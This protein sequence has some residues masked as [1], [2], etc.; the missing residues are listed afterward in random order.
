MPDP[1]H[2]SSVGWII[3]SLAALAMAFNQIDDFVKRRQGKDGDRMV[4]P[5][6]FEIKAATEY[7]HKH[8][9]VE[10]AKHNTNT[11]NAM[12]SALRASEEKQAVNLKN[13]LAAIR[14]EVT[15]MGKQV[16]AIDS[17]ME[18]QNQQ[19]ARIETNVFNALRKA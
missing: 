3:L 6:P 2:F 1:N 16:A 19:L 18:L 14:S 4:G 10:H 15:E 7:L 5:Q 12:F 17:A 9:F 8:E 13:D 11:H